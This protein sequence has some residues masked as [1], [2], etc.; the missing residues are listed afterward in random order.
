MR[1]AFL[2]L[3]T[4]FTAELKRANIK[5]GK[6]N[7][8][9]GEHIVDKT[10]PFQLKS[11]FGTRPLYI[12]KWNSVYPMTFKIEEKIQTL[13]D[14]ETGKEIQLS[15]KELVP[16]KT[17]FYE[18]GGAGYSPEILKTTQ[19]VRF[20]KGMK[21]YA[22]GGGRDWKTTMSW[23]LGIVIFLAAG[24]LVYMLVAGGGIKL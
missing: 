13:K 1:G 11:A 17:E 16:V 3:D 18:K 24:F 20:L 6:V 14:V 2:F 15:T 7:L 8:A 10:T 22:E 21:K 19:D 4:D 23:V 12:M 5:N 9:D